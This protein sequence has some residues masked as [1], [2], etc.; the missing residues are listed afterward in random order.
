MQSDN[1]SLAKT[2]CEEFNNSEERCSSKG[3]LS[4]NIASPNIAEFEAF[5]E[6]EVA[7]QRPLPNGRTTIPGK[8]KK[9]SR[10]NEYWEGVLAREKQRLQNLSHERL[11]SVDA[12][13]LGSS[14]DEDCGITPLRQAAIKRRANEKL[15]STKDPDEESSGL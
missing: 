4:T 5:L 2:D 15:A 8:Q 3:P 6:Q 14:S 9:I 13:M 7:T 12:M 11:T 1:E 10:T